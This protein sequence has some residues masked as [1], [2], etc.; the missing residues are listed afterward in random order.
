MVLLTSSTFDPKRP[1]HWRR[2]V[3]FGVTIHNV[4]GL[5]VLS[6]AVAGREFVLPLWDGSD[7]YT[8]AGRWG[9]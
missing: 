4:P 5:C 1:R 8:G 7:P 6:L 9:L 3:L 2:T